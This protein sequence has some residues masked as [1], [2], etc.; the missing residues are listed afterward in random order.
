MRSEGYYGNGQQNDRGQ[1][2]RTAAP[3]IAS[4]HGGGLRGAGH[5]LRRNDVDKRHRRRD[6]DDGDDVTS[7]ASAGGN[8]RVTLR[9]SRRRGSPPESSERE[10]HTDETECDRLAKRDR[11]GLPPANGS[12]CDEL[13]VSAANATTMTAANASSLRAVMIP[14][15]RALSLRPA[16]LTIAKVQMTPMASQRSLPAT[17]GHKRTTYSDRPVARAAVTPGSITSNDCQP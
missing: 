9:T 15:T 3:D 16:M 6:V 13:P 8:V 4:P 17:A 5:L 2:R 12:K 14:S 7:M 10:E 1:H 11:A